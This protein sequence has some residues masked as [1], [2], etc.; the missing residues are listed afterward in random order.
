MAIVQ[1]LIAMLTR[2]AGK[3]LNTAFS[4]ATIL[5]FGRVSQ[6]RQIYVSVIAFGSVIWLVVLAG[7]AFP[8][9][10]TFLLSFVTVPKW[11]DR[12]WIRL[13]MLA[14]VV[15]IPALIGVVS[16]LMLERG[17]RP[18]GIG[19][20]V[21][22]VLRGYPY[23]VGLALTLA[24]MT[25][26]APVLRIRALLKR[27]TTQHVPVI[28]PPRDYE[29]VVAALRK[30]LTE[31]GLPT[32]RTRASWMLRAPTRVLTTFASGAVAGLVA[33]RMATLRAKDFEVMLHPSDL[34]VGGREDN[35][36]HARA[37][38][39]EH[40]AFTPAYLTWNKESN[41]LEDRMRAVWRARDARPGPALSGEL[42]NINAR[43]HELRVPYEEWEVLFR[44]LMLLERALREGGRSVSAGPG[45]AT[46]LGAGLAVAAPHAEN[47]ADALEETVKELRATA[48]RM[49][50]SVPAVSLM[51][52]VMAALSALIGRRG[53]R[54]GWRAVAKATRPGRRRAA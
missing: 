31:G 46:A 29:T 20:I 17:R 2:S 38:I 23:T 5:L 47:I 22:T 41:E 10:G 33:E 54:R 15:L 45:W 32:E 49:P 11:V 4:W 36:V 40:V 53:R 12:K 16:I 52:A 39:A 3:L 13:G 9:I 51:A 14:A 34:V 26:F 8:A 44:Q 1:A 24:M 27:W 25:V 28:V 7:V 6:D 42:A 35:V 48:D 19:G 30:A 43:L 50:R 21:K 18:S 37:I